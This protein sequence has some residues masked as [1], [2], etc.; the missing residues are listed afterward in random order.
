M[1]NTSKLSKL[2]VFFGV[3]CLATG[4]CISILSKMLADEAPIYI[5]YNDGSTSTYYNLKPYYW[6][7][8]LVSITE[9]ETIARIIFRKISCV[10]MS[11]IYSVVKSCQLFF[12]KVSVINT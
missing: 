8:V 4:I 7:G 1:E 2:I 10:T 3:M 12:Q 11:D 6:G 5:Y 9:Q